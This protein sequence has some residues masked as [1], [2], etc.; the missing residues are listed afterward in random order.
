MIQIAIINES[1][2]V[3]AKEL[4]VVIA[5]LQNQVT[6]DFAPIWGVS[7]KLK[8][9]AS[10]SAA[11]AT[12]WQLILLDDSDQADALGY[13]ETT[14]SGRPLGKVFVKSDIEAGTSWTNTLSHELLE[15]LADPDAN[16]S[17]WIDKADGSAQLVSYEVCDPVEAD[18]LGYKIG[19]V[20]VSDFVLPSYFEPNAP[21]PYDFKKHIQ[22]PFE[23]LPDGYLSVFDIKDGSGWRQI[24]GERVAAARYIAPYGSRRERR[25][26]R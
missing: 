25:A 6:R 18:S 11:L 24:N 2:A 7:A 21:P 1:S 10:A 4:P 23:V 15:I 8:L 5:A 22:K 20:L 12:D 17:A 19:T 9:V 16:L 13:H 3:K 14:D 26:R